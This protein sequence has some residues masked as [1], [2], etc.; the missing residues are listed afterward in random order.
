MVGIVIVSHSAKLAEGVAELARGMAGPDVAIAPAGGLNLPGR[1]LGTD[2]A[3]IRQAILQVYSDDG[4]LVLMDL[5]SAILSTEM[6]V[7]ALPKETRSR[8]L[9]CEA[10]LVEGALA[11]AVQ[12]KLNSA[13]EQVAAEARAG[14][15]P[16][17][18]Q[19]GHVGAGTDRT[20]VMPDMSNALTLRLTVRNR[21]GLHARPAARFV[22]TTGR[23]LSSVLV[24]NQTT[25]R[26]PVNAKSINSVATLG[27]RQGHEIQLAASGPDAAAALAALQKLAD[28]N[29]GDVDDGANGEP[30]ATRRTRPLAAV[31]GRSSFVG[32]PASPGIALGPARRLIPITPQVP[33]DPTDDPVREW[34]TLQTTLDKTRA[35][36]RRMLEDV[37]QRADRQTADIFEAH[38]LFLDDEALHEPA[39]R[40]IFE[41]RLNAAAAWLRA[42][43]QV[44]DQYRALEDEY[45]RIRAAD[46][47]DVGRQ[48]IAGLLGVSTAP[49]LAGPGILIA[50][51]LTP[52][53]TASLDPQLVQGIA[54]A[55]GGPTSHSAILARSLGIPAV[56]AL[57]ERVLQIAEGTELILDGELGDLILEPDPA[58]A[59]DY[60]KK[61][62]VARK[63]AAQAKAASAAPA[64]TRDNRRIEVVANI[65][66][67]ADARAAVEAGAEGVGLFRTEFL[68]LDRLT[69]PDEDEQ[70]A[71]YRGAAEVMGKERPIIIRTL[72]VGG[73][74]PLPYVEMGREANPFLGWRAIRL[75]LKN[76]D[77]FKVQLRA[78]ARVA[79]DF[80]T[81]VMFPMIATL[82]EFR[83]AKALL[84]E[85][86]DE[87]RQ[88]GLPTPDRIDTGIMVEIPAAALRA[89]QF[90]REVDFFSVGT[91]DLTQYTLAAERGNPRVAALA[92]GL[93]PAV[94]EL[95][96]RTAEAARERGKWA[97]VC[98]EL[99][100]DPRAVPLLV[101][102][103]ITELSMAAPAIPRAKQLI[104]ELN[105]R[106]ARNRAIAALE[107][108]SAEAVRAASS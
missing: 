85:A 95:I 18:A 12:A 44:A 10:P 76:P 101:G 63:A 81:L 2:V 29:F 21:L 4:V 35:R 80:P 26:G 57:G 9:L 14:L 25:G 59:A 56:V 42:T 104:R 48:V 6:V 71:A 51:D 1:P 60:T 7:E 8:V 30:Q 78:I 47:E 39:R 28:E 46:V 98:G 65:G 5:G 54:T 50:S 43:R 107:L 67:L 82:A 108:E 92:D 37:A 64:V 69:A 45:Q 97:G 53:D 96:R 94:L 31:H 36:L 11:A 32:V 66:S 86:L 102:L 84:H 38:L 103:G 100:G 27:V 52:A 79:A 75:C 20:P 93:Q 15:T 106:T 16:K 17:V 91:N 99:A 40:A 22:Q 90:A 33:E 19:L 89:R 73:D 83:A 34:Q 72:D 88:R 3:L 87:I 55:L 74:K 49:A 70:Y 23:F 58:L 41:D 62:E 77:F 105:Y 13:L 68:F 61:R 24:T